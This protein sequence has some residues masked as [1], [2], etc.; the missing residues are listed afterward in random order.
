[1][2]LTA[3]LAAGLA[4]PNVVS[5]FGPDDGCVVVTGATGFVAGHIIEELLRKGYTVRGTVRDPSNK[6]KAQHLFDLDEKYPGTLSLYKAN[7][8]DH[9]L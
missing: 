6:A 1:M 7:L 2:K 8:M 3:L 9:G 4:L 5:A